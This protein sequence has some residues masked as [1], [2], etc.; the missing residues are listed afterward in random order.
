MRVLFLFAVTNTEPYFELVEQEEFLN[1]L[2]P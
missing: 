1:G 2:I